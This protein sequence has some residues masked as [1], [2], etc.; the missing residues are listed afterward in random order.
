MASPA[1][2]RKRIKSLIVGLE[3]SLRDAFL[4]SIAD[5][6]SQV[7]LKRVIEAL[8]R[9]DVEAAIGAMNIDRPAFAPLENALQQ[10][11]AAGG[12]ATVAGMPTL[13]DRAGARVVIRFD[14]R[15][16]RA[17]QW[18]QDHSSRLVRDILE[19]QRVSIRNAIEAA[20]AQGKGPRSIALDIVGRINRLTGQRE[21]GIIGL[22]NLQ[23]AYVAAAR[24]ELASGEADALRNYLD[25][26]R[27]DRRFDSQVLRAI[28][29]GEDLPADLIDRASSRYEARLLE[30][31]GEMVAR[32]ETMA[33]VHSAKREAFLQGLGLTGYTD[34]AVTRTWRSAGDG[35]VRHTH[36]GMNGQTVQGMDTPFHSPSGA[37]LLHPGDTTLG[38]GPAEIIGCRC[39]DEINLDFSEGLV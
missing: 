34:D 6:K 24:R 22:T 39:D 26:E 35:R 14:V 18:L 16:L 19:D 9:R 30:L 37:L 3:P 28:E 32:T 27:R 36:E 23:Q 21:G 10:A 4:A 13:F 33:A 31:R 11:Y 20:Y 2:L 25:R 29:N 15:N 7:A 38:A 1:V 12:A 8:E 5:I 17:E